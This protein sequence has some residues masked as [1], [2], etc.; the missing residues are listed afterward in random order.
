MIG[1][2]R[3]WENDVSRQVV[4]CLMGSVYPSPFMSRDSG[5]L[6]LP[7]LDLTGQQEITGTRISS[8]ASRS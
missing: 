8:P 4:L 2:L 3:W 7:I 5:Q 1:V 6:L